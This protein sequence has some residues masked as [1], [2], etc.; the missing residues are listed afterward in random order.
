MNRHYILAVF[1]FVI[2]G[3]TKCTG[4]CTCCKGT[5]EVDI[6][7]LQEEIYDPTATQYEGLRQS[8]VLYFDQS[9]CMMKQYRDAS[10]VFIALRPQLG[11][12][13]DTMQLMQGGKLETIALSRGSNRVSEALERIDSD[14]PFTDIRGVIFRICND[15]Q[16]AVL[17][18]DCESWFDT[19]QQ[20]KRNLD[21]EAY[22]SEPFRNWLRRG[23]SI[24]IVVEP[25]QEKW[26]GRMFD[27]KRFYFLF[28]NDYMAAPITHL[29]GEIEPFLQDGTCKLFKMTNADISTKREGDLVASDLDFE[30]TNLNGF[31]YIEIYNKWSDIRKYIMKL[32]KY[33]QP[34]GDE[35]VPLIHNLFFN[36]G[37]NYN[38]T[39]V[40]IK[41]TNITEKYLF[42]DSVAAFNMGLTINEPKEVD[43]SEGFMLDKNALQNSELKVF[44]TDKI[45]DYLTD[46]FCGNLI[47]LDFVIKDVEIKPFQPD[48]FTWQS[49]FGNG[50]AICVS[51]SIVNALRDTEVVPHRA[52]NRRVIHTIF[53]KTEKYKQ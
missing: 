29:L 11:Q 49:L 41:A 38:V 19:A 34:N 10:R 5:L 18:T 26:Q 20:S 13:C 30:F 43:M 42:I 8:T 51:Q 47:R 4:G 50:E 32:D 23:H 15:D 46:E 24:Y 21:F 3:F 6:Q 2:F 12:Y 25:Y 44:L 1:V 7:I 14:V 31:D 33:G 40:A 36:E 53:F 35:P 39:D 37:N 45:F 22:M 16:Q 52:A 17:I 28:T 48:M 27:K 9:T